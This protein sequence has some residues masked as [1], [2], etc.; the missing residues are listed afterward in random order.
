MLKSPVGYKIENLKYALVLFLE[1]DNQVL[2]RVKGAWLTLR[3]IFWTN[4]I[5]QILRPKLSSHRSKGFGFNFFSE[6]LDQDKAKVFAKVAADLILTTVSTCRLSTN[7]K[8]IK[9][10]FSDKVA[11][12]KLDGLGAWE[13]KLELGPVIKVPKALSF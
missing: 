5:F 2:K 6:F 9:T 4:C 3:H 12:T 7:K 11:I 10:F 8:T 13:K 1:Q